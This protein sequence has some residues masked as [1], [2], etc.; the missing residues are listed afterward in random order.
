MDESMK[1]ALQEYGRVIQ[2]EGWDAGERVIEAYEIR[3]PDFRRWA[4]ALGVML[5]AREILA[6]LV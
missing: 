3:F 6:G 1:Q 5:R 2:V 4:H